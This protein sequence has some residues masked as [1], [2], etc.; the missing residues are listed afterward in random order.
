MAR[1][2]S[3]SVGEKGVNRK[4]DAVTVQEL[5]NSVPPEK[6][7]A[8]PKLDPDGLPWGKTIAAIRRFQKVACGS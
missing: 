6:G 1:S 8:D 7:G 3:A 5:L 4:D 2:I